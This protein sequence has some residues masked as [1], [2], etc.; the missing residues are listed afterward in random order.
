MKLTSRAFAHREEIPKK[1]SCH[2]EH[3]TSPP[4]EFEE[5]PSATQ[6]LVLLVDDPDAPGTTFHHWVV[7]NIPPTVSTLGEGLPPHGNE[8]HNSLGRRGWTPPCPPDGEH[9]YIFALHALDTT[10]VL[11]EGA[12]HDAVQAAMEGH[13]LARA[14]LIGLYGGKS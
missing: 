7:W 10:L 4:L 3:P 13:V 11:S 8:G 5:V 1:Y 6:T 9:R 2:G 14:E 12:D